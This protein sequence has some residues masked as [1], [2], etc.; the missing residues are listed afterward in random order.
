MFVCVC[1]TEVKIL[2]NFIICLELLFF[3]FNFYF[4]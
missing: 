4:G 1:G 3:F 2:K